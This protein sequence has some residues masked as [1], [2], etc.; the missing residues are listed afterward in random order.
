MEQLFS[1]CSNQHFEEY[2][3]EVF[4]P[5]M[6]TKLQT[7]SRLD[8][9]LDRVDSNKTELFKF[10][11]DA[12]LTWFDK[13]DKQ[14]VI[15]RD[16]QSLASQ[17]SLIWHRSPHAIKEKQTV[18]CCCMHPMHPSMATIRY[19]S[20]LWTQM[21]WFWLSRW[22]KG[23]TKKMNCGWHLALAR[24]SAFF[25]PT[26]WQHVWDQRRRGHCLCATVSSFSGH[27]KM[28]AWVIWAVYPDLTEALLK[29]S[30]ALKVLPEDVMHIIERFVILL[31]DRTSS[32]MDIKKAR[33]KL[34]AKNNIVQL[35]PLTKAA[36]E[37]HVK[38]AKP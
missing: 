4:I 14:L 26:K 38:R 8:L 37:E 35:I 34:F 33:R 27:G 19:W 20:G 32:C 1:K 9:V 30:A 29:L 2:A 7:A 11:S 5:Y 3:Q 25:Q 13:E 21:S 18:A 31:Y 28:T 36:L 17:C 6:S 12:L 10:L 22:S 16:R 24:V 23:C 15:T